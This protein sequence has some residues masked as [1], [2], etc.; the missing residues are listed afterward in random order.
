MGVGIR[1]AHS[2]NISV[3]SKNNRR[4]MEA[5]ILSVNPPTLKEFAQAF[6]ATVSENPGVDQNSD[7]FKGLLFEKIKSK[8]QHR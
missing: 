6:E 2:D 4:P 5:E 7:Q 3:S 8:S 1:S